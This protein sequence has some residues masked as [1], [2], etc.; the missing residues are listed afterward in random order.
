MT[1]VTMVTMPADQHHSGVMSPSKAFKLERV[2]TPDRSELRE[3]NNISHCFP[4]NADYN[5][6]EQFKHLN[7]A[8]HRPACRCQCCF[9]LPV[10][11]L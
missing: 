5:A 8:V 11:L 4:I 2:S 10:L 3:E 6:Y 9:T 1:T 7:D